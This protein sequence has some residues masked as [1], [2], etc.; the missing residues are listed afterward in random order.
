MLATKKNRFLEV[1][2]VSD[3]TDYDTRPF[4]FLF[5]ISMHFLPSFLFLFTLPV[6]R[7]IL[8]FRIVLSFLNLLKYFVKLRIC[9]TYLKI[10]AVN[11]TE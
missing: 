8:L 9:K 2:E 5:C 3:V 4:T 11:A 10:W 6:S 7:K 1:N